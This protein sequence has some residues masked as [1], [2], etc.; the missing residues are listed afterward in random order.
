MLPDHKY[1]MCLPH[2]VLSVF[3]LAFGQ[4]VPICKYLNILHL[5]SWAFIMG[6][7][8]T[9]STASK[10]WAPRLLFA[11]CHHIVSNPGGNR[12]RTM[13]KG[14]SVLYAR[15]KGLWTEVLG[16]RQNPGQK[17]LLVPTPND[18]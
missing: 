6:R 17:A 11:G 14:C 16:A 10:M 1:I 12:T 4:D 5:L 15:Y 3:L 2:N 18:N 13:I 8:P 9:G 7:D